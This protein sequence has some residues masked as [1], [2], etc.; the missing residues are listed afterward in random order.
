MKTVLVNE[1][2]R[3]QSDGLVPRGG[4][5]CSCF[6]QT[7]ESIIECISELVI[8]LGFSQTQP[9]VGLTEKRK[10]AGGMDGCI[11]VEIHC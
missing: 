3:I 10:C 1:E 7:L 5:R 11:S 6:N 9:S 2:I 4:D 8:L